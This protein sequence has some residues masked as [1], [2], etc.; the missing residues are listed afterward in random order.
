MTELLTKKHKNG[1]T[2]TIKFNVKPIIGKDVIVTF[3]VA[4]FSDCNKWRK[5][6]VLTDI[7]ITR[8]KLLNAYCELDP[9]GE[10]PTSNNDL[11]DFYGVQKLHQQLIQDETART[12]DIVSK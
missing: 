10:I 3:V 5:E 1:D 12:E 11:V 8:C 4:E 6:Q 7:F 2:T 9:T